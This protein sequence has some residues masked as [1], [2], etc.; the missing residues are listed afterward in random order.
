MSEVQ[1][2]ALICALIAV[3]TARHNW[4]ACLIATV[5]A[6]TLLKGCA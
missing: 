2:A 1:A 3:G 6:C 5:A 4:I